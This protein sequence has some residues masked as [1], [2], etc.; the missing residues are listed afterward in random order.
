[1]FILHE[2]M[3]GRINFY[4]FTTDLLSESFINIIPNTNPNSK[5]NA[6]ITLASNG[7]VT[8]VSTLG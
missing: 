3:A 8:E 2:I 1:M 5:V 6:G 4:S 7:V